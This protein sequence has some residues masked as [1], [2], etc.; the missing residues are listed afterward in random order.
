MNRLFK[1]IAV[2]TAFL[3]ASGSIP[4]FS[5]GASAETG[6]FSSGERKKSAG[7]DVSCAIP[8]FMGAVGQEIGDLTE[9]SPVTAYGDI[10]ENI[11]LDG[12]SE[13]PEKFDMREAG[14][15][16]PV[17]EQRSYGAC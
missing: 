8:R 1:T 3:V 2:C 7:A 16:T 17:K 5:A 4:V 15:N 6:S 9:L 11:T 12:A 10:S 14:T 13:L